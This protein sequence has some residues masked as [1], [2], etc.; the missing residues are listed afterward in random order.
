MID[1]GRNASPAA[2]R[3]GC[4]GRVRGKSA[5]ETSVATSARYSGARREWRGSRSGSTAGFQCSCARSSVSTL[6]PG[7]TA[8]PTDQ[9]S[10]EPAG[11]RRG[12]DPARR[13]RLSGALQRQAVQPPVPG[14]AAHA[15]NLVSE[16][17]PLTSFGLRR[18]RR[19]LAPSS[20][21]LRGVSAPRCATMPS[22]SSRQEG[23]DAAA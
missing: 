3:R 7:A 14:R 6:A 4:Q 23:R 20:Q 21:K 11:P 5:A 19:S 8:G 22:P 2:R 1:R 15:S 17:L 12:S 18:D 9:P 16:K 13:R 10:V